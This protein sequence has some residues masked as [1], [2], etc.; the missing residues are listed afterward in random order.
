[1]RRMALH[2][3]AEQFGSVADA[4]E[5]G[6][7]EYT[8]AAIGALAAELRIAPGAR[9][10]DL[11]AGTGKLTAALLDAGFDVTAVEPQASLREVLAAKV[12][13]DRALEG[14][15]EAIPLPD[16]AFE[17]VTVA[18]AFHW[19]DHQAAIAEIRRVLRPGGG[20]AVLSTIPDWS[21]A[22]W[23]HEL[24]TLIVRGRPTHP[25]FDGP[26]WQDAVQAAGGWREPREIRVT[27]AQPADP[28]RIVNH[29]GSMSWVAAMAEGPRAEMLTEVRAI[30]QAGHSPAELPVHVVVG[31]T[32][33]A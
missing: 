33:L 18:D 16:A 29:V 6:R 10:L 20:L 28:E 11:G 27:S 3:L 5:H 32:E 23:A 12:G 8:P 9:V 17:A 24:G 14:L 2:P 25:N 13:A 21:G 7:P 30:L 26:S 31:L 1:M 4:Y 19:F 22:S 15:A